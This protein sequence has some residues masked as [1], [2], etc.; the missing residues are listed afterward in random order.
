M[1]AALWFVGLFCLA[2]AGALFAGNNQGSVMLFWPPY[3]LDLSLNMVVLLLLA[4]FFILYGALRGFSALVSLPLQAKRWRLQQRERNMHQ[5]LLESLTHL[6]AGRFL[7]A[8]KA[9]LQSLTLEDGLDKDK[10]TVAYRLQLRT[11]AHM[12]AADSS[13]AL[14][15]RATRDEHLDAALDLAPLNG[16]TQQQE[17][18]EGAQMRSARWALDD[19]DAS[20]ALERLG[21]L[22]HGA[23][24]R[25]IA[26][27]I[28]LKATR[29][30]RQT[31]PALETARLLAKHKAF[32]PEASASLLRSLLLEQLHSAHDAGQLL[33]AWS[34]A[35]ARERSAPELAI[36]AARRLVALG[37]DSATAREWLLPVWE[38]QLQQPQGLHSEHSTRLVLALQESLDDL[39]AA[40]LGRIEAA[41]RHAPHNP[42]LQYLAGMACLQRQ[43]WGKAQQLLGQ[44]TQQL[45]DQALLHSAWTALAILAERHEA[46]DEAAHAWKQAALHGK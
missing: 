8:R 23:A 26:L 25:T 21:E 4:A 20:G 31:Q 9:A 33:S 45:K 36:P 19:R 18:R 15:D 38:A 27:R 43:L 12:A 42:R 44:S 32:S 24:R 13:H 40:W 29:L 2:V 28:K 3:R 14:Q 17:L 41:L 5:A 7:R 37:G 1:R 35:E 34:Q 30:A 39:D 22:P 46:P 10:A 11:I 16:T 6:H